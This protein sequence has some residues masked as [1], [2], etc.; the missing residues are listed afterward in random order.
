[1]R[2][3]QVDVTSIARDPM[4]DGINYDIAI[5]TVSPALN[6][7]GVNRARSRSLRASRRRARRF[8]SPDGA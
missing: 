1:M 4:Y 5:M 8:R 7:D 6:L 3:L 2:T